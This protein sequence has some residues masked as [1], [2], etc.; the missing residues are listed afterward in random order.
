MAFQN[1]HPFSH[2]YQSE[3]YYWYI[4][5]LQI[6]KSIKDLPKI[7]KESIAVIADNIPNGIAAEAAVSGANISSISV[8]HL[9]VTTNPLNPNT[10]YSV[11]GSLTE[12]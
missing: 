11:S 5:H 8:Q 4:E 10:Y 2:S 6:S 1:Q 3:K 9:I 12:E 7:C